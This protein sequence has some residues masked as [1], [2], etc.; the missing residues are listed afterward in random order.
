MKNNAGY[1]FV[2]QES[3]DGRLLSLRAKEDEAAMN[4]V[5]GKQLWGTALAPAGVETSAERRILPDGHLQETY[6]FTNTTAFPIFAQKL[7]AGI[8]AT[9]NDNYETAQICLEKRCHTHIFC[10]GDTAWVMAFRMGGRPP[11][12][13]LV[14]K[15]GTLAG[16]SVERDPETLSND[17]GDFILHPQLGVLQ[18]G[19]TKRIVWELFWF[20]DRADFEAQASRKSGG[21]FV[22]AE[23]CTCF[24]GGRFRFKALL[25]GEGRDAHVL[26]DGRPVPCEAA[27]E[28]GRAVVRC[29]LSADHAG[30][31][32]VTVRADG[33]ESRAL[34]YASPGLEDLV[35]SR[36]R[37][38]AQKQQ[39]HDPS[40]PL[41]GAY[42][43]YDNEEEAIYYSHE[44]DRNGGRE[45][46]GM[47]VLMARYLQTAQDPALARSLEEYERY[48]YR[49]LYDEATGTVYND[50]TRNLD[51]HRKYNYPWIA[52]FQL[53]LYALKG[54]EKYLRDALRTMLR[55]YSEGGAQ[56]YA[57]GIPA[58][59]LFQKLE[60]AGL[61]RQAAEF[62]ERFLEHAEYI[63]Q[64]GSLYPG[65][66]VNFEQSIV[67]P[68][69]SCLIQA[70]Q[71]TGESRF[72]REAEKQLELLYL[73]NGRQP[74]YHQFENAI[75][76]WDG[77]WFGK[78]RL[79]GD[80]YPHYWS[81]LT[82][83]D[84]AL[85]EQA[86]GDTRYHEAAKASLRGCLNLFTE[87]GRACCA[88]VFPETVNGA[89][90]GF[91]D[92]LANDQDWA[93][94]FALKYRAFTEEADA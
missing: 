60:S 36:C 26:L 24:A 67:A 93:L 82:G 92:P 20:E 50:A 61:R 83:A 23:Q 2:I 27:R 65:H 19:Q 85:Y 9:F 32:P 70:Y 14:L 4:W 88:M 21:P 66:E 16:Y 7:D 91:Y 64:R 71:L 58:C 63:L 29:E 84:M 54:D 53:E 1:S 35:R 62:R 59:E 42:L 15:E 3:A 6:R 78:R 75:R 31:Y 72:L 74:D 5:E 51:W 22:K 79:F 46:V 56:F 43:C 41:D 73:F 11:H 68:G 90:A 77:Y 38:I 86:T 47:G 13:G 87:Q 25:P 48:V 49:E 18:P 40:S 45:R 8:Y 94:Y 76:H 69:V 81:T 33:K 52:V 12:L 34:F 37:F 44:D 89:R 39:Y 28:N 17:R 30:A 57:I 80:T 10:G 55:Y